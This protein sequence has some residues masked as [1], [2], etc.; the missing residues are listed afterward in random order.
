[1]KDKI[2]EELNEYLAAES[3]H[4]ALEE[5]ADLLFMLLRK[6]MDLR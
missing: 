3:D 1:M 5:L 6:P 2:E 4:E